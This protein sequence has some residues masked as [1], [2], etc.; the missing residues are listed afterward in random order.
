VADVFSMREQPGFRRT[1]AGML[2]TLIN[3]GLAYLI[4]SQFKWWR[5]WLPISLGT[6]ALVST[7]FTLGFASLSLAPGGVALSRSVE[8]ATTHAVWCALC[9]WGFAWR[10]KKAT[11]PGPASDPQE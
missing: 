6:G 3:I 10:R 5:N 9:T 11:P 1:L 2:P 8:L 4:A 7:I